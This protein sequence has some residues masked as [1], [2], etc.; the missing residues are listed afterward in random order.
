MARSQLVRRFAAGSLLAVFV[1]AIVLG[2]AIR[3]AVERVVMDQWTRAQVSLWSAAVEPMLGHD[4]SAS[5][6]DESGAEA[7]DEIFVA[8]F[9]PAG[10]LNVKL[11]DRD[12][13]LVYTARGNGR[14][15]QDFGS[16]SEIAAALGGQV[17]AEVVRGRGEAE[18]AADFEEFGDLV[19]VYVPL[20]RDAGGEP[21]AV[22]EVYESFAPVAAD[23]E[24][25]T[26]TLWAVLAVGL[27]ALYGGQIVFV[28]RTE[29]RLHESES[30]VEAVNE[31]LAASMQDLEQYSMGTL[32]AFITAVDAKD[33]YTAGHSL[34][35]ADYAV[36]AGRFLGLSKAELMDL[37]RA[38]LLHDIGK[39]GVP[40]RILLKPAR[41]NPEETLA[42]QE[43][44]EMSSRIAEAVPFL[45]ELV[46][47]IR[48]HHE[49]WDGKGYPD[50][51]AGEAT[52]RLA[53][54]IAVA[55]AFDAMTSDRP[56]RPA[57]RISIAREE[58]IRFR[59]VQFDPEVVDA[60][61]RALDSG[62]ISPALYHPSHLA[63]RSG[64]R[65][66]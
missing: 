26:L 27:A 1:L 54:V 52:P 15:G 30:E 8:H 65:V 14:V 55:D 16:E 6:L 47:L 40:E 2:I 57:L 38:C 31:R 36:T 49:R 28:W 43:H 5:T 46:P 23:I 9:Q 41:L 39:I 34:G 10:A 22:L 29:R 56:Y 35:V 12:G 18:S 25:T 53:R 13:V 33:S 60:F 24:S 32:Q 63:E 45:R 58:L 37:E 62:D 51:L 17:T 4:R 64:V 42:I 11:F 3:V 44:A 20:R 50:G 48:H 66:S 7:L 19:E 61:V 59:G 21:M